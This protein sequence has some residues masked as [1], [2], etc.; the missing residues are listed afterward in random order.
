MMPGAQGYHQNN[1]HGPQGGKGGPMQQNNRNNRNNQRVSP[2]NPQ[3]GRG[4]QGQY[5]PNQGERLTNAP[6]DGPDGPATSDSAHAMYGNVEEGEEAQRYAGT[7]RYNNANGQ[8]MNRRQGQEQGRRAPDGQQQA[9]QPKKKG[10]AA[11]GAAAGAPNPNQTQN[12]KNKSTDP[13]APGKAAPAGAKAAPQKA[14]GAPVDGRRKT[15]PRGA[16][17]QDAPQKGPNFNLNAADF[18][19]A[20]DDST[21]GRA[22]GQSGG[23]KGS[24]TAALLGGSKAGSEAGPVP[25]GQPMSDA[26]SAAKAMFSGEDHH[27]ILVNSSFEKR[28]RHHSFSSDQHISF[29][30]DAVDEPSHLHRVPTPI[31]TAEEVCLFSIVYQL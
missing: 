26:G 8:Q 10:N 17:A 5:E 22:A 11:A 18:P 21:A 20:W 23:Q 16:A 28:E 25:G 9:G 29:V 15:N 1:R 27:S 7:P 3:Q 24:W 30:A 12:K 31:P 6:A 4:Y 14:G 2:R 13:Q 19:A